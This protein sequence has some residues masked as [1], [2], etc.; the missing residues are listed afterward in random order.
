MNIVFFH[1]L[2]L[3]HLY[4]PVS[5]FLE[6]ENVILHV[7]FSDRE[8]A[9]LKKDYAIENN[10]FNLSRLRDKYLDNSENIKFSISEL[11]NFIRFQTNNRFNYSTSIIL[12][13]TYRNLSIDEINLISLSYFHVWNDI[14]A[15]FNPNLF[16]HEPPA[17]FCTH[18]AVM[19]CSKYDAIYL[20]QIHVI[21]KE[22][23][24]WIFLE[25]DRAFPTEVHLN[26]YLT[27]IPDLN[28]KGFRNDFLEDDKVLFGHI[29]MGSNSKTKFKVLKFV[30]R[31]MSLF[32]RKVKKRF[33]NKLELTAS[34]HIERFL[35]FN[36]SDFFS[37][38]ENLYG[39]MFQEFSC[40]P[41]EGE[42]Y[43]F[44]PLHIEP[45]AVVLYYAEG[46][47]TGQIKLIENI[48]MQLP[49]DVFLYVKDHPHG[50]NYRNICDYKAIVKIPK[51]RL[52]HSSYSGK[53]LIKKSI[54]VI[55]INSTAGFEAL[56]LNKNVV[57]FGNSFYADFKGVNKINHIKGLGDVLYRLQ[58][59]A[60]NSIG[61]D[62]LN[63]YLNAL[64]PGFVSYFAN[65]H[66][67]LGIDIN[68]NA[69]L[70]ANGISTLIDKLNQKLGNGIY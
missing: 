14:F 11:D 25:G 64:K 12:D 13:R 35:E 3:V 61:D 32:F 56:L 20:T 10:V 49:P 67:E 51:V 41:K 8:V 30:L 59:S 66:L 16:F 60:Q 65:R 48:A 47:Y 6:K 38:I 22:T 24:H 4:A 28:P 68:E 46:W 45:E 62:D 57:C 15:E 17:I 50:G 55:T 26:R 42:K 70:V 40:E 29:C 44:Y 1:R 9:I 37:D 58:E 53:S 39:R 69:R 31:L 43:Y 34:H 2:D 5:K 27:P 23:Y 18:L 52:I 63:C 36:E 7:A 33:T 54:G 19:L 21:G